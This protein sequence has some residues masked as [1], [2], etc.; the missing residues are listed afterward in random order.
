M[1]PKISIII[2]VYNAEKYLRECL[3]SVLA[4]TFQDFEV[5]LINDGSTDNSGQICDEYAEK[6]KRIK[7]FHKE[8]GGVSAARNLGIENAKGEWITFV[9]SD[10]FIGENFLWDLHACLDANSDFVITN[11]SLIY[12]SGNVRYWTP[13]SRGNFLIKDFLLLPHSTIIRVP[14]SKLF[15]KDIIEKNQLK[16]DTNLDLGEDTKFVFQYCKIINFVTSSSQKKYFYRQLDNGLSKK[17]LN[18]SYELNLASEIKNILIEISKTHSIPFKS[19]QHHLNYLSMRVIVSIYN[20]N[21]TGNERI[22]K[23]DFVLKNFPNVVKVFESQNL[24]S[25]IL[26]L[27]LRYKFYRLFDAIFLKLNI[28]HV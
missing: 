2:P 1:R 8:N 3:D 22:A 24:K 7:V 4:Q 12:E 20:S 23:I 5:L 16:F 9:D 11:C 25:K 18:Y 10:D 28:K 27:F 19:L 6:D 26:G 14:F 17:K 15:K 13:Y 21:L